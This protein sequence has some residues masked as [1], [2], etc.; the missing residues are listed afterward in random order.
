MVEHEAL[1]ALYSSDM[2]IL[3]PRLVV[4]TNVGDEG[5]LLAYERTAGDS[6][7]RVDDEAITD[8]VLHED[9]AGRGADAQAP[10]RPPRPAP[11]QR[12]AGAGRAALAH[13]L[14]LRRDRRHRPDAGHRRGGAAVVDRPQGGRHP[15]GRRGDRR[16]RQGRRGQRGAAHPAA[17][18]QHGDAQVPGGAQAALRRAAQVRRRGERRRRRRAPGPAAHQAAHGARLRLA[19][20]RLLPAH[21]AA[22]R[23]ERRVVQAEG[24]PTGRG[25]CTRSAPRR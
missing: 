3:T 13:R 19:G 15:G 20:R 1:V 4:T 2:G 18:A 22:R 21:P 23:R 16:D 10:H 6:L 25:R 14:R 17:R 12:A 11:G 5:F 8:E 9:L 7:D 24:R